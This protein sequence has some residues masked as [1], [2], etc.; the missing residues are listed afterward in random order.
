MK[1]REMIEGFVDQLVYEDLHIG[2]MGKG[3]VFSGMGGSGIVGDIA[4]VWLEKAGYPHPVFSIRGYELPSYID[5][6]YIVVCTSYS[7]N[8]EETLYIFDEA[9]KRGIKPICISSGGKLKERAISEG[10]MY[11]SIPEGWPPRYALGFM[12]SKIL[13]LFG[14]KREEMEDIRDNLVKNRD[15]I[16]ET[17]KTIAGRFYSYLP[18]IY[19][20]MST[21]VVAFRWK[22]QMNENGKTQC[23]YAVLPEMHHNEV[24]GLDNAEVRSKCSFLL[25]SDPEDHPRI[26]LRVKITEDVLKKLGVNPYVLEGKG[27]S[28]LSRVLY[29]ISIG[30]WVSYHIAELYGFDPIPVKVIDYIKSELSK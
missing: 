30:D 14:I 2:E 28:Y 29:L 16:H 9:L 18:V 19:S 22:T 3:I 26:R 15:E 17:A 5:N 23:Y 1:A 8:T 20:T 11:L 27:N 13:C 7:G 24:V 12:L 21:E 6:N 25:M 10:C 4:K